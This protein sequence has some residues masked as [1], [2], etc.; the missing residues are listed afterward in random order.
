MTADL[1]PNFCSASEHWRA[2]RCTSAQVLRSIGPSV[3]WH[4]TSCAQTPS[5]VA[6]VVVSCGNVRVVQCV[7]TDSMHCECFL[8]LFGVPASGVVDDSRHKQG[9]LH[10]KSLHLAVLG[11]LAQFIGSL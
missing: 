11:C 5:Q 10:H 2:R 3:V 7:K 6:Y 8:Y 1:T 9:V 4:T